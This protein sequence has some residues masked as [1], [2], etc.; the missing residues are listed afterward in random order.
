M[1]NRYSVF[2]WSLSI[3]F[4]HKS[5][6]SK[7]LSPCC[8]LAVHCLYL[9][10]LYF[11]LYFSSNFSTVLPPLP[12]CTL[13]CISSGINQACSCVAWLHYIIMKFS[14][15]CSEGNGLG[16]RVAL[17]SYTIIWNQFCTMSCGKDYSKK[18]IS[19]FNPPFLIWVILSKSKFNKSWNIR[20]LG[21]HLLLSRPLSFCFKPTRGLLLHLAPFLSQ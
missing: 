10:S 12:P 21:C 19:F 11:A 3:H 7:F 8:Q 16:P 2:K 18:E 4:H 6:N 1:E 14:L 15:R 9:S 17:P 20:I 5:N 13:F